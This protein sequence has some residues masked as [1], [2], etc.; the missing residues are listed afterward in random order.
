MADSAP[1]VLMVSEKPLIASTIAGI[2]SNNS[3]QSFAFPL[4][5]RFDRGW[6]RD[7][8]FSPHVPLMFGLPKFV[9]IVVALAA[10]IA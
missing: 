9:R 4:Q 10:G 8:Y 1:T 2:L 5:G 3:V 6:G 7:S